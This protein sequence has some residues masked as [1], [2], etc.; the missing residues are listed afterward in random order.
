[1]ED[2]LRVGEMAHNQKSQG[3]GVLPNRKIDMPACIQRAWGR[4]PRIQERLGAETR[5]EH[6]ATLRKIGGVVLPRLKL[7]SDAS[8]RVRGM[9]L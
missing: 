3:L 7:I 2:D 5:H 6:S 1:M 9:A 8:Q 4:H